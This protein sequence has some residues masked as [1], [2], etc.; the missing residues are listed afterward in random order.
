MPSTYNE[1][2]VVYSHPYVASNI[3]NDD[4]IFTSTSSRR[5]F[6][7]SFVSERGE[8]NVIKLMTSTEEYLFNYGEPNLKK[9]GQAGY[10]IMNLL[11]NGETVYVLR[12]MPDNA[13]FSHAMVNIQSKVQGNKYVKNVNGDKVLV[14]NIILRP[15]V[16]YSNANNSSQSLLDYELASATTTSIDGYRNNLLFYVVPRGRGAYYD[17]YGFRIYLNTSYDN[18]YDFRVYNFEVIEFNEYGNASIVEGPFYVALDPDAMTASNESMFI[19]DVVNRYSTYMKVKFN[20]SAYD[21][22]TTLINPN[23]TPGHLDV[24]SGRTRKVDNEKETYFCE[25]TQKQEDVHIKIMKYDSDGDLITDGVDGLTNIIDSSDTIEQTVISIDNTERV[26]EY[27]RNQIT[28]ENMK[29]AISDI[30]T[31]LYVNSINLYGNIDETT[32]QFVSDSKVMKEKANVETS[33]EDFK[34]SKDIFVSSKTESAFTEAYNKSVILDTYLEDLLTTYRFLN[35][36]ARVLID[37]SSTLSITNNIA[38][39]QNI[40]N[41]KEIASVKL[42]AYKKALNDYITELITYKTIQNVAEENYQLKLLLV[43]INDILDYYKSVVDNEALSAEL[44]AL[45]LTYNEAVDLVGQIDSEYIPDSSK[46]DFLKELYE[47]TEDLL[48]SML[49]TTNGLILENEY[50]NDVRLYDSADSNYAITLTTPLA[51]AVSTAIKKFEANKNNAILKEEMITNAKNVVN[52]QQD[53]TIISRNHTYNTILSDFA[54]PI[55]FKNGSEGD[56]DESNASLRNKTIKNLLIKGYKGLIDDGITSKKIIPARFVMDANYDIEVKNAM[57]Q[58]VTEIRDDIFFYCDTGLTASPEEALSKRSTEV[59]F[60][61]IMIGIYTQDFTVY[62]EYTGRDI[63]VTTPYFL[64]SKIPYCSTNY[65][66][67]MP[68]AGNKRGLIDGFKS[69]SWVPNESYKELLYNKKINYIESDTTKTR[70][71]AQLTSENRNTP[72]SNINN[73]ITVLDIRNDVELLA[74]DYQFE[75]NNDET[76]DN[77]QTELNQYLSKYTSAQAAERIEASVYASDYDKLQKILR[78]SIT[79]KFYD[80]IERI[81]INLD[82]VKN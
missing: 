32:N 46:E 29:Q 17:K 47:K 33:W 1:L 72:L 16:T 68:I 74:E 56:L 28:L 42:I 24:I 80:I 20:E 77:F 49:S 37:D 7:Y 44:D 82:V 53:S 63:K 60:S 54:Q 48:T 62:D 76:I 55:Q 21:Y 51:L 78:V 66:L 50:S 26:S 15:T 22:L 30:Y 19:E 73:V 45:I 39:I 25:E 71:G 23:V 36:Y 9:F 65:G 18:T 59:N 75:F 43:N 4:T 57:H 11:Q 6:F 70:F 41:S 40:I 69:I 58:L 3:T 10:N 5:P 27:T 13:G 12:V 14:D 38:V 64:A 2:A 61:S 31:G 52:V 67:H 81:L 35:A 8:D 34:T 79:I